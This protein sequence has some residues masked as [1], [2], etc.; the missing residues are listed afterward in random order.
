MTYVIAS[1][2]N[3][4]KAYKSRK[5]RAKRKSASKRGLFCVQNRDETSHL[6]LYSK[7]FRHLQS[8]WYKELSKDGF[9]DIEAPEWTPKDAPK[10]L[11]AASLRHIAESFSPETRHFYAKLRCFLTFNATF[12]DQY[13]EPISKK[14]LEAC[15]LFAEGVPHRTILEKLKRFK[16]PR[17][18]LWSLPQLTNHFVNISTIW[19]KQNHNGMDFAPDI[20]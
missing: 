14:K 3:K 16:G 6:S 4:I 15:R 19:N 1:M 9:K 11:R 17:L 7:K 5:K 2:P 18:N 12:M 8:I 10:Q 20:G 13:G